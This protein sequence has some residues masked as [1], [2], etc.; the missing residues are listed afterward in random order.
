[1]ELPTNYRQVHT[2]AFLQTWTKLNAEQRQ[3][4]EQ[5][6]GP[7]LVLAGPGTGKTQVLAA[8]IGNILLQTDYLPENIL[9][10]TFTDAGSIAMRDRLIQFI[11]P[12][13]HRVHIFTFH[14]FCNAVIQSN[15]PLFGQHGM[16]PLTELERIDL[17]RSLIDELSPDHPLYRTHT[18]SYSYEKQL[19]QLFTLM[20]K[21]NW[22]SD[23]VVEIGEQ[24]I[25]SLPDNPDFKYKVATK[26]N[27]RGDV[28]QR[29]TEEETERAEKL[30]AAARL[31]ARYQEK[32]KN[33]R[34]YDYEDM[35]LW[36][37]HAFNNH[38][39]LLRNYQER[40]QFILVDEY[41]DTNNA[42]N[43]ILLQL[44]NYWDTPN[45]FAVGDDDQ[46]IYEFQGARLFTLTEFV[47]RFQPFIETIT[48]TQNYRST[49]P[50]LDAAAAL[51]EH[52]KLRLTT[53]T[54]FSPPLQKTLYAAGTNADAIPTQPVCSVYPSR[55]HE[56]TH[57]VAQV[58]QLLE[59]GTAPTEVAIIY[60]QHKQARNLLLLL[61]KKGIPYQ[62][63]RS[64]DILETPL[65]QQLLDVLQYLQSELDQP[66]SGEYLLFRIL[67]Y[68]W[69][70]IPVKALS[71]LSLAIKHLSDDQE[72]AWRVV[73]HDPSQYYPAISEDSAEM[74]KKAATA[75]DDLQADAANLILPDLVERVINR[76][77]LLYYLLESPQKVEG[78]QLLY[79]FLSFV[80]SAAEKNPG[81]DL[82]GLMDMLSKMKENQVPIPLSQ[83]VG[84]EGGV[85][86]LTAH[87]AKGLEFEYVFIFDAVKDFWEPAHLGRGQFKL[88]PTL[89]RSGEEDA[90]EAR[91]RLF[92]VAMTRAKSN[93][94]ISYART[95]EQGKPITQTRF[96]DELRE[97]KVLFVQEPSVSV[98]ALIQTQYILLTQTERPTL[99]C[100]E[101]T[102]ID[103][104]LADFHLSISSLNSYLECPLGFY[105]EYIL[106]VPVLHRAAAH[107]GSALHQAMYQLFYRITPDKAFPSEDQ[108]V[109]FFEADMNTRKGLLPQRLYEKYLTQ[110]IRYLRQLYQSQVG[111]WHKDV[112]VEYAVR[113]VEVD[114]IP[115]KGTIDKIEYHP[116]LATKVIDYKTSRVEKKELNPPS[117]RQPIGGLFWRQLTFYKILFEQLDRS[118]RLV[119]QGEIHSLTPNQQGIF[120]QYALTFQPDQDDI[121]Q[122][123]ALI[124]ETHAHIM[125][126]NFYTGCGKSTCTWCT[127]VRQTY[128]DA[129]L[130]NPETEA[131]DD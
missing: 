43:E 54:I 15:L 66:Q 25:Q 37:L 49:Q 57:L 81:L 114:G 3:A 123:R 21:E 108:F 116:Q 80:R 22:T 8:R 9:C 23:Y 62:T 92:Y 38:P 33:L 117:Q 96:V 35:I 78:T 89:S 129:S 124:R 47:R 72:K 24:W 121:R 118:S 93:L 104:K 6:E 83:L 53:N 128:T 101:N 44:L 34:R 36:V 88:P 76:S 131:L 61:Q 60:S 107:Y 109:R 55:L 100:E 113:K 56:L 130:S 98:E 12:A 10:L 17:I 64:I 105:F 111:S 58:E 18:Y 122:M 67:H 41:Q 71:D 85:Q 4:A 77:G 19:H 68:R 119:T 16:E 82:P 87:S 20:S 75:L 31:F 86:L 28:N 39:Y 27:K 112:H 48:L 91:R 103:D 73:I 26:T 50:I 42:Q 45:V 59:Q 69:W 126:K 5:M 29:K 30:I 74:L 52:N 7:M 40:Y 46:S 14:S 120:E 13:A 110:G 79:A 97:A 84:E 106:E 125:K 63:R 1:M 65:V 99:L 102:F 2:E 70:N 115:I 32:K 11:G 95:D 94:F 127:F 90:L 51:I